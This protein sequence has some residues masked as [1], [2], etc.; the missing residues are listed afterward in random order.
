MFRGVAGFGVG[1]RIH[2]AHLLRLSSDLPVVIEIVDDPSKI[3]AFITTLD[4]AFPRGLITVEKARVIWYRTI[5]N[6]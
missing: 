4:D 1:S 3:E 6:P 2:T 5:K